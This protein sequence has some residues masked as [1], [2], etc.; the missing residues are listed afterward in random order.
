MAEIPH[1]LS[2]FQLLYKSLTPGARRLFLLPVADRD[3][4]A[5]YLAPT[6]ALY[7]MGE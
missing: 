6:T 5:G 3:G 4:D 1:F 2:R 7:G